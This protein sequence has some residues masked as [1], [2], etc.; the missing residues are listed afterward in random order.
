MSNCW[1]PYEF[2]RIFRL[3]HFGW[4]DE[5]T[6]NNLRTSH[7]GKNR[8]KKWWLVWTRILR[9]SYRSVVYF[10]Y[11]LSICIIIYSYFSRVFCAMS[12]IEHLTRIPW[13]FARGSE[14]R[15]SSVPIRHQ[16]V[17]V[18]SFYSFRCIWRISII[19]CLQSTD[20]NEWN[21][22]KINFV[23]LFFCSW[24]ADWKFSPLCYIEQSSRL[25]R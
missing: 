19:W 20:S 3:L 6:A 24:F 23:F 12:F 17:S 9:N 10:W 2:V 5:H 11:T 8:E 7:R 22:E 21:R 16:N 1:F 14:K 18:A 13:A 25:S 4:Q 15:V